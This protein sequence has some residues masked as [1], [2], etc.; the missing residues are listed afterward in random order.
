VSTATCVIEVY[1]LAGSCS[2]ALGNGQRRGHRSARN[3]GLDCRHG[4]QRQRG[5]HG[6]AGCTASSRASWP[7]GPRSRV[8]AA[9][10]GVAERGPAR[11]ASHLR[12][13]PRAARHARC[14]SSSLTN[15]RSNAGGSARRSGVPGSRRSLPARTEVFER[16][17]PVAVK[18]VGV[19][20]IMLRANGG[21]QS[22]LAIDSLRS[23]TLAT[24][25][26]SVPSAQV[27]SRFQGLVASRLRQAKTQRG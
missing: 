14:L 1:G 15:Y 27:S 8:S 3:R 5:H 4:P 9:A 23:R 20:K 19:E 2:T 13:R 6:P 12:A 11:G 10:I 26:D 21:Q 25:N 24:L 16:V 22:Q 18:R 7:T 17:A